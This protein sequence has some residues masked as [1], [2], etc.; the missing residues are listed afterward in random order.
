[1]V[2]YISMVNGNG[3]YHYGNFCLKLLLF[4]LFC[5]D[6]LGRALWTGPEN[7]GALVLFIMSLYGSSCNHLFFGLTISLCL[8]S[9]GIYF[10][11]SH[12][13]FGDSGTINRKIKQ[14]SENETELICTYMNCRTQ[15]W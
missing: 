1:M 13:V 9:A 4:Y 10:L 3:N 12:P 7:Y 8:F 2:K 11:A 6:C 5:L 14:S 15:K